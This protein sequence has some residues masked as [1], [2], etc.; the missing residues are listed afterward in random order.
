MTHRRKDIKEEL[1]EIGPNL[2]RL[3]VTNPYRVPAGY[4]DNLAETILSRVKNTSAKEELESISPLLSGLTKTTPFSV[5]EGYFENLKATPK[6]EGARIIS[7]P[8]RNFMKY[9][10]AAITI[11]LITVLAWFFIKSPK[12]T[13]NQYAVKKDTISE[14]QIEKKIGEISD[15]EIATYLNNSSIDDVEDDGTAD[16]K[17][18][19]VQVMLAYISDQDLEKYLEQNNSL[20][21]KLN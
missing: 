9:A 18:E 19:D 12:E 5:P 2:A 17:D 1:Q 20:K 11:G 3:D 13:N 7:M 15:N 8:A 4:F 21:A 14:K 6:A 10:A 16:L